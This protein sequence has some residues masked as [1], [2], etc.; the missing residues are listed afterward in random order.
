MPLEIFIGNSNLAHMSGVKSGLT[1]EVDDGATLTITLFENDGTTPVTGQVFPASFFNEPGGDYY[2]PLDDTL[3]LSLNYN[4]VA[5]VDGIGSS[6]ET[7]YIRENV[8]AIQ[9]GTAC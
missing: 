1:G 3:D 5:E 7:L 2:A 4:Y 6:G 8:K 9:R